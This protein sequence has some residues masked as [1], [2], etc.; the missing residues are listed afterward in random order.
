MLG[1]IEMTCENFF[2]LVEIT[3]RASRFW[4]Q[5]ARRA[6]WKMK[7]LGALIVDQF[8]CFPSLQLDSGRLR[9]VPFFFL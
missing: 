8:T 9:A 7:F 6:S 5:L 4:L 2:G 3:F 1:Y